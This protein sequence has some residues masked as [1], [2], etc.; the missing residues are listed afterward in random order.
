ML[1]HPFFFKLLLCRLHLAEGQN[2]PI[3]TSGLLST[4]RTPPQ[5]LLEYRDIS[6][7]SSVLWKGLRRAALL[8]PLRPK[9]WG[10][11]TLSSSSSTVIPKSFLLIQLSSTHTPPQNPCPAHR[12][13]IQSWC[14]T[15]AQDQNLVYRPKVP[16]AIEHNSPKFSSKNCTWGRYMVMVWGKGTGYILGNFKV[17][18]AP[19]DPMRKLKHLESKG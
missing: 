15:E 12:Q 3:C 7:L 1:W 4:I 11:R 19:Y 2:W 18:I 6:I 5:L 14:F 13:R 17:I 9:G 8:Y 16:I 10:Q